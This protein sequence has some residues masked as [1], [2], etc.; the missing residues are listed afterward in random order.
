MSCQPTC[1]NR[2]LLLKKEEKLAKL[3]QT[4]TWLKE[5]VRQEPWRKTEVIKK[6][7][8]VDSMI[9]NAMA[10]S[11]LL[12]NKIARGCQVCSRLTKQH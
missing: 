7:E 10:E 9:A 3:N 12:V 2:T 4:K 6:M 1:N 5:L 11:G 8:I